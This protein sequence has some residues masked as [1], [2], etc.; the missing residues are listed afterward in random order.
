MRRIVDL[1]SG[2]V[3][4][5]EATQV[6]LDKGCLLVAHGTAK[7]RRDDIRIPTHEIA[8]LVVGHRLTL[9]GAVLGA[10]AA[11]GGAVLVLDDRFRPS[12]LL[13]PVEGHWAHAVRLQYQIERLPA[14]AP[15]YWQQ[16]VR[17]KLC[18]QADTA[19]KEPRIR[20][21]IAKVQPGDPDN[22]EAVAAR[23]YWT[24]MFGEDFTR[25]SDDWIN[26]RLNYGYSVVRAM[27]ARAVC[28][29]G[30]HPALGVHHHNYRNTFAL[31]DDLMEPARPLVD[32]IVTRLTPGDFDRTTKAAVLGAVTTEV[33]MPNGRLGLIEAYERVCS[34]LVESLEA[35]GG[36]LH[37]PVLDL[38]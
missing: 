15:S 31:A 35:S 20:E 1:S 23:L 14:L 25:R 33:T 17:A 7:R 13:L 4:D 19:S 36:E 22:V 32:R 24:A 34:S 21:L 10:V 18:A 2:R 16:I 30:L 3:D 38:P 37:L 9:T 11:N 5:A 26:V 12:G 29:A 28:A 6:R 8:V 27:V